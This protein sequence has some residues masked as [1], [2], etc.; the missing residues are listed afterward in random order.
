MPRSADDEL[1]EGDFWAEAVLG[2]CEDCKRPL[3]ASDPDAPRGAAS[4]KICPH[5]RR[6]YN[7][8]APATYRHAPPPP[9]TSSWTM[10]ESAWGHSAL[11]SVLLWRACFNGLG[12]PLFEAAARGSINTDPER[13]LAAGA[14]TLMAAFF[15]LG[16]ML[17]WAFV[18]LYLILIA[19]DHLG[20][21][22]VL[23]VATG[24][25]VGAL[26]CL[27]LPQGWMIGGMIV[28]SLAGLTKRWRELT[29]PT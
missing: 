25:G 23:R 8:A 26:L 19:T 11:I 12:R 2:W 27:G 20:E 18:T 4:P 7:P 16:F 24:M 9:P 1:V 3:S 5:C 6:P 13:S 21:G 29:A 10:S 22:L 28:G 17:P 15:T 14:A